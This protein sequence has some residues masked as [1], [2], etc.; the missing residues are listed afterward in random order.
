MV[1]TSVFI[2]I[3]KYNGINVQLTGNIFSL[4]D[5]YRNLVGRIGRIYILNFG[6][7]MCRWCNG[8]FLLALY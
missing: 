1:M 3:N 6:V 5:F 4:F 7:S 8:G 2:C